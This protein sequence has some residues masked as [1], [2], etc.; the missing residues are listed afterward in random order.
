VLVH[1]G[2]EAGLPGEGGGGGGEVHRWVR[3]PGS[4]R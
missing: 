2:L 4:G 1:E 3:H